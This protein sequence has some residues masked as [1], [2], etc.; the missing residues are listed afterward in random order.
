MYICWTDVYLLTFF[1][2]IWM[3]Q[4]KKN[5]VNQVHELYLFKDLNKCTHRSIGRGLSI[6]IN[7]Y[8]V[9]QCQ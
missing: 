5:L 6:E 1:V 8:A 4:E 3:V 9:H 2:K 7:V